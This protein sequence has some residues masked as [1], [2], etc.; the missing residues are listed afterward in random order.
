M[1]P[2]DVFN[3][4]YDATTAGLDRW[5]GTLTDVAHVER[6]QT[7]SYWRVRIR[8]RCSNTCPAELMLSRGQ[9]FDL[10][11]GNETII[12]QPATDLALFQPLL[13]AI[14]HGQVVSRVWSAQA[15]GAELAR[16]IIVQ[17]PDGRAWSTRRLVTAGTE[18]TDLAALAND[19][20]FLA[21][22]RD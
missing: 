8:P 16:E 21:Y 4:G 13:E 9:T 6:E 19:R 7:P 10:D 3:R 5:V 15:T 2:Q 18:E 14:A 11:V 22:R 1:Q 20:A 17:L 12:A